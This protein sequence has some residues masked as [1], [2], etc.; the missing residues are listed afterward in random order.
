VGVESAKEY[1]EMGEAM[2]SEGG[3]WEEGREALRWLV[4]QGRR[5]P[6]AGGGQAAGGGRFFAT[7]GGRIR[8]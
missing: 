6:G 8:G 2:R 1:L 5:Q 3:R 7:M 4:R